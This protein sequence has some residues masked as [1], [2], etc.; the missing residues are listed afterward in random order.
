MN[1]KNIISLE[2]FLGR[3]DDLLFYCRNHRRYVRR[4]KHDTKKKKV[5][6]PRQQLGRARFRCV[7]M[8]YRAIKGTFMREVWRFLPVRMAWTGYHNFIRMNYS[9]FNLKGGILDFSRLKMSYGDLRL[10]LGVCVKVE[11]RRGIVITWKTGMDEL[12]G[13]GTDRLVSIPDV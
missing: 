12:Q 9:A 8:L 1:K 6:S 10:P 13:E 2:N 5:V 11:D 4:I 7:V 3:I